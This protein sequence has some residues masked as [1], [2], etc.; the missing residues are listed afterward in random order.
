MCWWEWNG[1][2]WNDGRTWR[3]YWIWHGM[4]PFQSMY[5]RFDC[6]LRCAIPEMRGS[7]SFSC[8]ID[9][10]Y[11]YTRRLF[12]AIHYRIA[13]PQSRLRLPACPSHLVN[14]PSFKPGDRFRRD[15]LGAVEL[16]GLVDGMEEAEMMPCQPLRRLT[17]SHVTT[18]TNRVQAPL[19]G[20]VENLESA[21]ELGIFSACLQCLG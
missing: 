8:I 11:I 17:L 16:R 14:S 1:A 18:G 15:P 13:I 10:L 7:H 5:N 9:R 12:V 19:P 21:G 3:Q 20:L 2:E 6:I 4:L